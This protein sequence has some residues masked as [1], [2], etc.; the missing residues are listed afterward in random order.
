MP[1]S[2]GLIGCGGIAGTWIDA[3]AAT[4]GCQIT[5]AYDVNAAAAERRAAQVGAQAV[6]DID[7]LLENPAIGV[8]IIGTPTITHPDLVVAAARA[9]KH[10]LC[11]KPMALNLAECRRMIAACRDGGVKLAIGHS[12]RFWGAFRKVRELV[13]AGAIGEPCIGQI[14]RMWPGK[15]VQASAPI[16]SGNS[17]HWRGDP[18]YSGG[19]I[20]E[21]FIHELDFSRTI[22]GEVTSVY[23]EATGKERYGDFLSPMVLQGFIGYE[24]GKTATL[25]MG[26]LIAMPSSGL[27][28]GGTQGTLA[29]DTWDGP[30]RHYRP[31]TETPDTISSDNTLAY[32]LELRDLI[33][34]IETDGTPENSGENGLKNVGLCL[35][36]YRS[37][38]EGTRYPFEKGLPV[39]VAEE[40]QYIGPTSIR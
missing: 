18:Q 5:M 36:M 21:G 24:A 22:F 14:H 37:L 26:N 40:Y 27:W 29:F 13:A 31:E 4:P 3:V 28:I 19:N 11:E 17:G 1:Y 23:F 8:V 34:A 12:L 9:G 16:P 10:V 7:A 6:T 20:L 25:R 15:P 39:G 32:A 2:I 35:A 38:A 33:Q 30:V